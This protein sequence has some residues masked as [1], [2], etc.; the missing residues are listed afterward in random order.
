[1]GNI[2]I[3]ETKLINRILENSQNGYTVLHRIFGYSSKLFEYSKKKQYIR[4][5]KDILGCDFIKIYFLKKHH[6]ITNLD[7]ILFY[8]GKNFYFHHT[9]R[10]DIASFSQKITRNNKT[11]KNIMIRVENIY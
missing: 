6:F 5:N 3:S 10:I 11:Y 1:M 4:F 2:L 9:I 7:D 8:D